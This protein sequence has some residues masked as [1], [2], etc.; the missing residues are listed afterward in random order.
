[1]IDRLHLGRHREIV[2]PALFL[3]AV[4]AVGA[5]VFWLVSRARRARS[6]RNPVALSAGAA[7]S[8]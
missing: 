6:R 4:S 5:V 1:M 3:A 7:K 2:V 8:A